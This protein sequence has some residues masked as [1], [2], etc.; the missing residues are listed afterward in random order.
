[1]LGVLKLRRLE[2]KADIIDEL[3]VNVLIGVE[4]YSIPE[5]DI[6]KE[7]VKNYVP[8]HNSR[9]LVQELIVFRD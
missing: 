2:P 1:M 4:E 6:V 7:V 9:A 5:D 3:R 8:F